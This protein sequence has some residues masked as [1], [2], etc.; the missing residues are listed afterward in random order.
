MEKNENTYN[1]PGFY[2]YGISL[3]KFKIMLT[4]SGTAVE[5]V[6]AT[7]PVVQEELHTHASG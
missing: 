4:F 5:V 7:L 6:D 2:S 3:F 1:M